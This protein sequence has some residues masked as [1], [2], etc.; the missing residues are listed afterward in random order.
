[1][2]LKNIAGKLDYSGLVG[3][4]KTKQLILDQLRTNFGAGSITGNINV[5]PAVKPAGWLAQLDRS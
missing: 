5:N 4:E 2:S 1:L 3:D